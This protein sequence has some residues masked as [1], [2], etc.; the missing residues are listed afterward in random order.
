MFLVVANLFTSTGLGDHFDGI[1]EMS[2]APRLQS[3]RIAFA[4]VSEA[5][6]LLDIVSTSVAPLD[7]IGHEREGA[8]SIFIEQSPLL[9]LI[10]PALT[11]DCSNKIC[12]LDWTATNSSSEFCLEQI[13]AQTAILSWFDT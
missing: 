11:R 3:L 12:R 5:L 6:L 8:R 2:A 9:S 4:P 10:R 13:V 1:S 7:A